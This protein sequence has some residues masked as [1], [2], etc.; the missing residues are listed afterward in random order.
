MSEADIIVTARRR[1]ESIQDVPQVINAVTA[2]A[3]AKLNLR[4]FE[5]VTA[6]SPGL[7]ISTAKTSAGIQ[8]TVRGVNFNSNV[9]GTNGTIEYYLNDGIINAAA[10][11]YAMFDISR[12]EVLRGPQGTLRGRA[13]PSGSINVT[14]NKPKLGEVGATG[15]L[16]TNNIEGIQISGAANIPVIT[17]KLGVRL[18][19]VFASDRGDNVR[20]VANSIDPYNKT[21][22]VRASV[23][24][25]PFDGVF[26][27][28]FMYQDLNRRSRYYDQ[29]ESASEFLAGAAASPVTIR[30]RD[31]NGIEGL[32]NPNTT[33]WQVFNWQAKLNLL[34]QS[35]T[36]LGTKTRGD[37]H[38]PTAQDQAG[39]FPVDTVNGQDFRMMNDTRL[40][41]EAHEVR[42]QNE[43]LVAGMFDYVVGAF[44]Y[45]AKSNSDSTRVTGLAPAA[46]APLTLT[47]ISTNLVQRPNFSREESVFGNVTAHIGDRFE[48]SGGGRHIWYRTDVSATANGIPQ[49]ALSRS[50]REKA[51]IYSASAK[52]RFSDE[53][54]AYAS[55]SSSWRPSVNA[56]GGPNQPSALQD[57]FLNGPAE[58]STS[59]EAGVKT[60]FFYNRAHINVSAYY[61]KFSNYPY[62]S[63]STVFAIDRA[64]NA[65]VGF[66]YIAVVPVEVKGVESDF[67]FDVNKHWNIGG[68]LSYTDGKITGGNLPCLD[69]NRDGV[70]D[71]VTAAPTLAQLDAVVGQNNIS[72]CPVKGK[73]K[74]NI[75]P[76]WSGTLTS[77]YRTDVGDEKQAY[78]RGLFVWNGPTENDPS[79][80]FD[81]VSSYGIL[82]LY[83]GL[84]ERTGKW[85]ISV[86]GKNI[87]DT[88]RVLSRTN[89]PLTTVTSRGTLSNTNYYGI[90]VTQPRE[91]GVN[92]RFALGSR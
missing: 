7:Q 13:S 4:R 77:E 10:I 34:G 48:L 69:L 11:T 75:A 92:L 15:E 30:A 70:P 54:M 31:R 6:L 35:L 52:Y 42:L 37:F 41:T 19:G 59:Y 24:A 81:S 55:V 29:V 87:T 32:Y 80:A 43:S 26:V 39:V 82:N 47:G 9:S 46:P 50:A 22:G 85:D 72:S 3:I 53:I 2:D 1:E 86:Y 18:A 71:V 64:R 60:N 76:A 8:S 38:G 21:E 40:D 14:T 12:V 89:G 45:Q 88:F 62:R 58:R 44:I 73:I 78:L 66:N 28:D 51:W 90:T 36:Y 67:N 5:D 74:A 17:D 79:N 56:P 83:L 63:P 68:V 61:Q 57:S 20:A 33:H 27:V 16:T 65:V 84:R 49:P 23:R 91:F 25:D